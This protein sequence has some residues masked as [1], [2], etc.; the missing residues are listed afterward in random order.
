MVKFTV[1]SGS[2]G[3]FEALPQ[4]RNVRWFLQSA[5]FMEADDNYDSDRIKW[6]FEI[7]G[8]D[9]PDDE[10]IGK[11]HWVYTNMPKDPNNISTR[12]NLYQL[13]EGMSGGEFNPGDSFD[14]D[15]YVGQEYTGDIRR[16]Q[17]KQQVGNKWVD[18]KND[19]GTP[20]KKSVLRNLYPAPKQTR[21]RAT[22][23]RSYEFD[24]DES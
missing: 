4:M 13:V 5:E 11:T 21:E 14:T 15:D 16:E 24:D 7:V 18:A 9:V 6:V 22:R 12:S 8:G 20:R 17:A 19:D 1:G 10:F 2:G 23:Q 3:D